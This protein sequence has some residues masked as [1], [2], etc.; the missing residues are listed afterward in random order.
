MHKIYYGKTVYDRKETKA[1]VNVL[2][3]HNFSLID[4]PY[5]KKL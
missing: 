4:R 5:V 3:N 1:V 2:K